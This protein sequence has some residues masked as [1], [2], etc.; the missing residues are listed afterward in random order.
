MFERRL[1]IF[2]AILTGVIVLLILR[3]GQLQI[4]E[5]DSWREKADASM[6]RT[7]YPKNIR[8]R[9]LDIRGRELAVDAPCIDAAV[10]FRAIQKDEK[11]IRDQ[12]LARLKNN[13]ASYKN[14]DK[15]ARQ[16]MLD[17]ERLRVLTDIDAMFDL[18]AA[19]SGQT[20]EQIEEIKQS[21][22][23]RVEIRRRI[24]WYTRYSKALDKH[25]DSDKDEGGISRFLLSDE[26]LP[27][28]DNFEIEVAE[29]I[30]PHVILPA[31]S[32]NPQPPQEK[33]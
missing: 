17:N 27:Q 20:R 32:R 21:I 24:V 28:I 4:I 15:D 3:A 29:Q 16:W 30:E 33:N 11:W 18:L 12:A 8:G 13:D 6:C 7:S 10:D 23:Q 25:N 9:I 31:I 1:K 22:R 5:A 26:P 19:E 2:F 14:A